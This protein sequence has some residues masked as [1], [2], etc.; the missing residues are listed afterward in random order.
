MRLHLLAL[1]LAFMLPLAQAHAQSLTMQSQ[2][3]IA[4][5]NEIDQLQ[6]QLQQLQNSSGSALGGAAPPPPSGGQNQNS[7]VANLLTQVQQLQQQVQDLNGKVD[8]LR[9]Q[10]NTQ[11]DALEKEIGDLKFQLSS[12]GASGSAAGAAGAAATTAAAGN[13]PP[14]PPAAAPADPRATLKAAEAAYAK[15]D[16][17]TAQ[18][19][20]QT[21]LNQNKRAPEAY[22]AQYLVAQALAA[23][24]KPQ[25]AAIAFDATYNMNHNGSYA[26]Q[27]LYGLANSLNAI[28]QSEAACDTLASL[29]S[30]FPNP[31]AELQPRIA[32]LGKKA[33]CQ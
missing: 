29:N 21:I 10:V 32:A 9:N 14:A 22:R 15:H 20:A 3:G 6:A 33:H 1:V 4:L 13:N 19:L 31:P 11:H 2:E 18:S 8:E 28:G 17:A 7:V 26:P 12:G 5:Q 24:G 23:Q 30:Q 16:Y 27:A 25:E